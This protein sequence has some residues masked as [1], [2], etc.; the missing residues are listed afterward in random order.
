MNKCLICQKKYLETA[1][2]PYLD[3]LPFT[4]SNKLIFEKCNNC[5]F[6]RNISFDN[7]GIVNFYSENHSGYVGSPQFLE[8][9][10]A[11]RFKYDQYLKFI[12]KYFNGSSWV[13]IGC[14]EGALLRYSV[15]KKIFSGEVKL[16]GIDY[17][18]KRLVDTENYPQIDYFDQK[19]KG[20]SIP[21]A[22]DLYTMFHVLEHI[23]DPIQYLKTIHESSR[24]GS[25]LILEV[26]DSESYQAH[27]NEAYWYTIFEHINHFS[28][29]SLIRL[30]RSAGWKCIEVKRYT[31]KAV[32]IEYPALLMAFSWS[33][34]PQSKISLEEEIGFEAQKIAYQLI[35]LSKEK[36]ICLWGYSKFAKYIA[37]FLSARIP[38][39]DSFCVGKYE[40]NKHI[41]FLDA[42]PAMHNYDLI[43]SSSIT[44]FDSVIGAA[45]ACGWNEESIISI[46][47]LPSSDI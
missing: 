24:T 12:K 21:R 4:S 17:E 41:N 13:D 3:G 1:T 39:Y 44:G 6:V 32:G 18:A 27:I 47:N 9:E 22:Y 5:N 38:L 30:G 40:N 25:V 42:P 15:D 34:L 45:V 16:A 28:L 11:N 7:E 20:L 43:V 35:S 8:T 14:G 2:I 29:D 36:R 37:T 31:G 46:L 23:E 33:S 19:S 26:P 10:D